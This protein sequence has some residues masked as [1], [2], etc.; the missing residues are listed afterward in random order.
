MS[1]V[2]SYQKYKEIVALPYFEKMYVKCQEIIL[3]QG[4]GSFMN[5]SKWMRLYDFMNRWDEPPAFD[6]ELLTQEEP[7]DI[8]K[9]IPT[10]FSFWDYGTLDEDFIPFYAV[11]KLVIYGKREV[12]QG[13]LIK[14]L[15]VNLSAEIRAFLTLHKYPFI[16]EEE[17]V[18]LL[19]AYR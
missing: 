6:Y 4:L 11:R 3:K 16:E 8:L 2:N 12:Y 19:T 10:Y 7:L 17:G 9:K 1:G 15:I 18:F 5:D 14:P 13:R